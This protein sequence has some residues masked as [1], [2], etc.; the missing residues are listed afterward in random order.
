MTVGLKDI[1]RLSKDLEG[2]LETLYSFTNLSPCAIDIARYLSREQSKYFKNTKDLR[3]RFNYSDIRV[4][5][6]IK[7]LKEK[8]FVLQ[9]D[10]RGDYMLNPAMFLTE[11][12]ASISLTFK[13]GNIYINYEKA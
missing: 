11:P 1:G 12:V 5:Q 3:D 13:G 7:E 10:K 9:Q 2:F 4:K 8:G 6:G